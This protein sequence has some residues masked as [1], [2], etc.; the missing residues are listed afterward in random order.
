MSP[1]RIIQNL[2]ESS[3]L[4]LTHNIYNFILVWYNIEITYSI[5]IETCNC[6]TIM[7]NKTIQFWTVCRFCLVK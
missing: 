6:K 5:K 3:Y 1:N 7:K 4:F 2:G